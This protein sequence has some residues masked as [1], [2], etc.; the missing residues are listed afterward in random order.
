MKNIKIPIALLFFH[1]AFCVYAQP[2]TS[3]PLDITVFKGKNAIENA[4]LIQSQKNLVLI[5]AL[6]SGSAAEGYAARSERPARR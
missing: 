6:G 5:D 4:F 3:L 1:A 2:S